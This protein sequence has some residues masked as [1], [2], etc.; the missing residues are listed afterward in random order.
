MLLA[1][2][3]VSIALFMII[4]RIKRYIM[5]PISHIQTG[6][7]RRALHPPEKALTPSAQ[8]VQ[9]AEDVSLERVVHELP[10]GKKAFIQVMKPTSRSATHV[11]V[12]LHGYTSHGDMCSEAAYQ[13]CQEG[14]IVIMPDLPCHGRSDGELAYV[15]NWWLWINDI[16]EIL[17]YMVPKV[18]DEHQLP[19]FAAGVSLGGGVLT[20]LAIQRPTYFDGIVL[21]CPMLFVA[22]AVKPTWI[23]QQVF[24]LFLRFLLP[25]WPITPTKD[26]DTV[27]FRI[28]CMGSRYSHGNAFGVRHLKPRLASAYEFGFRWPEWIEANVH[29]LRTP[30]LVIHGDKDMITEPTMSQKLHDLAHAKDKQINIHKGVHHCELLNC[31]PSQAALVKMDFLPEQLQATSRCLREISEWCAARIG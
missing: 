3:V 22:D 2:V 24:K 10:S 13:L 20:C 25:D 27:E 1:T 12:F 9:A 4:L 11:K 5:R 31:V 26:M 29:Q 6:E 7:Q 14:A 21:L 16:W 15:E 17:D 23:T 28:P 18:R 8:A 19:L 30:F